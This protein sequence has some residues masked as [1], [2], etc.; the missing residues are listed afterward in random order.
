ME[1]KKEI[2]L[3]SRWNSLT[4][5]MVN[6]PNTERFIKGSEIKTLV[7][8]FNAEEKIKVTLRVVVGGIE[9][10]AEG[11]G[12]IITSPEEVSNEFVIETK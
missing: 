4:T 7:Y 9:E 3:L 6:E 10:N 12:Q 5:L 2:Q 8:I 11:K 1:E